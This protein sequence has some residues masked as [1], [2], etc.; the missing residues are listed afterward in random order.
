MHDPTDPNYVHETMKD[1]P[2]LPP[3]ALHE[4][5]HGGDT[6][7]NEQEKASEANNDEG[8]GGGLSQDHTNTEQITQP[9]I[10]KKMKAS[11]EERVEP[12]QSSQEEHPLPA[13]QIHQRSDRES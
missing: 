7:G 1:T 6:E 5:F 10:D 11:I 2:V 9:Q 8:G 3:H 4:R 12:E 13:G